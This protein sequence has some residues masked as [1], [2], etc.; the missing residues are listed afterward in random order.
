ME[1][2]SPTVAII[3]VF[4]IVDPREEN[5][6]PG[7][8]SNQKIVLKGLAIVFFINKIVMTVVSS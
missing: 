2:K 3:L 7:S 1:H 6:L 8:F 5:N 4:S